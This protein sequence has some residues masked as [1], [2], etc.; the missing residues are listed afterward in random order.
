MTMVE[1]S[2]NRSQ[3]KDLRLLNNRLWAGLSTSGGIEKYR[4]PTSRNDGGI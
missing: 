2:S 3:D 4:E 1:P